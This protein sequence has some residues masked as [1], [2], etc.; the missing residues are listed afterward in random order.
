MQRYTPQNYASINKVRHEVSCSDQ[1][2]LYWPESTT[3]LRQQTT[4]NIN[5]SFVTTSDFYNKFID[6]TLDG[7]LEKLKRNHKSEEIAEVLRLV[8]SKFG[9]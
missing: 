7:K 2:S 3:L 5:L 8:V 9:I 1:V 4:I 6:A